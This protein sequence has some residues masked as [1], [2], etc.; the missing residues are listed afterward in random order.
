MRKTDILK[1]FP[2]L[3]IL[4]AFFAIT[5]PLWGNSYLT[6]PDSASYF[7]VTRSVVRHRD[8]DFKNDYQSLRFKFLS[9]YLTENGRLSNDW[10]MGTGGTW[11]PTYLIAEITSQSLHFVGLDGHTYKPED[12][13]RSD[14][15]PRPITAGWDEPT[16]APTGQSGIYRLFLMLQVCGLVIGTLYLASRWSEDFSPRW[17]ALLGVFTLL[18]GT[19]VAFYSYSFPLMSHATSM[20][21][22]A[23]LLWGWWITREG[24]TLRHW[25]LLGIIAGV[26]ISI[27]PQN[28]GFL[29]VFLV[30]VLFRRPSSKKDWATWGKGVALASL[31]ALL[32]FSPQMILWGRLYGNPFQLPKL[33]EMNWLSPNLFEVLFS[34][35]HGL[36]SWSP[37]LILVPVGLVAIWKKNRELATALT[38]IILIQW[39]INAS[40][41]IWWASGSFGNRRFVNCGLPFAIALAGAF[42]LLRRWWIALLVALPLVWWNMALWSMERSAVLVLERY[43]PWNDQFF[44]TMLPFLNPWTLLKGLIGDFAGF[45]WVARGELMLLGLGIAFL[46]Y[47]DQA[48]PLKYKRHMIHWAAG[49][50]AIALPM[51]MLICA[52]RTPTC[53]EADFTIKPPKRNLSLFNNYYEAGYF[54]L[55]KDRIED[56]ESAYIKALDLQPD[57]SLPW[58]YLGAIYLVYYHDPETALIYTGKALDLDPGYEQALDIE[59]RALGQLLDK[60]PGNFDL[61]ERGIRRQKAAGKTEDVKRWED[62]AAK[63][64]EGSPPQ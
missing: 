55:Q 61:L 56:A 28:A 3:V 5:F 8:L 40:N 36:I 44:Q 2:P 38:V 42:S 21:A 62:Y 14:L 63:A 41:E 32:A 26:M 1:R 50:F 47:R 33:E 6:P 51:V 46:F 17:A 64:R 22:V 54:Y 18:L 43:I 31:G 53:T 35:Y 52:I 34:D 16:M 24:R 45:R 48:K 15:L 10:P 25:L 57:N 4:M 49:Y 27:R 58:R 7:A 11:I 20:A 13:Y 37:I 12:P 29:A 30:E 19:P 9:V 59:L 23:A 60:E 39:Y